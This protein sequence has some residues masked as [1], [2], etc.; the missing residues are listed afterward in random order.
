MLQKI[1]EKFSKPQFKI[2]KQSCWHE[3]KSLDDYSSSCIGS[4]NLSMTEIPNSPLLDLP[5][6]IFYLVT[7]YLCFADLI[8]LSLTTKT[9]RHICPRPR[10]HAFELD[11]KAEEKCFSRIHLRFLPP[12]A[13]LEEVEKGTRDSIFSWTGSSAGPRCPYC[14]HPLC[15]P[16]CTSALFLD[17]PTGIFF[18]RSLYNIPKATFRYSPEYSSPNPHGENPSIYKI[19][20]KEGGYN[21]HRSAEPFTYSTIWCDHHR[22]PRGLLIPDSKSNRRS[23]GA[24]LF[25][26]EYMQQWGELRFLLRVKAPHSIVRWSTWAN[27][28]VGYELTM[29]PIRGGAEYSKKPV[30][31]YGFYETVCRHCGLVCKD[32]RLGSTVFERVCRCF[33]PTDDLWL[34][35]CRRCG[36][37]SV[38]FEVVEA[39]G[40]EDRKLAVATEWKEGV[41]RRLE[42]IN[43][44]KRAK[45]LEIVRGRKLIEV[46][47]K[48]RVGIMDLPAGVL[49]RIMKFVALQSEE[50]EGEPFEMIMTCYWFARVWYELD[51][52]GCCRR[53]ELLEATVNEKRKRKKETNAYNI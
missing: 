17:T 48:C 11:T 44:K 4:Q 37:A 31:E 23:P 32:A 12:A 29:R 6:D 30:F 33:G 20:S 13:L 53:F 47:E 1:K 8:S 49:R 38:K 41:G 26:E 39:F 5:I 43:L 35:G 52:Y 18:P 3:P 19:L 7:K 42:P 34:G 45:Q 25:L 40:W 21:P 28:L 9:L 16:N 27:D 24:K 10:V 51:F 22:C 14:S 36:L 50:S 2:P 46:A 15:S